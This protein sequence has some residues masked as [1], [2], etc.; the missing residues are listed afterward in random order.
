MT[1]VCVRHKQS[2]NLNRREKICLM[3]SV[4]LQTTTVVL[5]NPH[6]PS[7]TSRMQIIIFLDKLNIVH[8]LLAWLHITV[9]VSSQNEHNKH[10]LFLNGSV[11]L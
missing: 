5:I 9:L 11:N 10:T 4:V 3:N 2:L 1:L 6:Y 7:G 8:K